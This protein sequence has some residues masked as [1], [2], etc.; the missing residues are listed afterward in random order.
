[1]G[2]VGCRC[3]VRV[4]LLLKRL[5]SVV[6]LQHTYD[7]VQVVTSKMVTYEYHGACRKHQTLLTFQTARPDR[8][9]SLSRATSIPLYMNMCAAAP[10][11]PPGK[12]ELLR[13]LRPPVRARERRPHNVRSRHRWRPAGAR[14]SRC[15]RR[16]SSN[17]RA[18]ALGAAHLLN[19]GSDAATAAVR[20]RG[21][22]TERVFTRKSLVSG[23]LRGSTHAP[24]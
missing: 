22:V 7:T 21:L 2:W 1:M 17:R 16:A 18:W 24:W 23:Q 5:L 19:L 15:L 8:M 11:R 9:E 14:S 12:Q 3:A 6:S 4:V 13:E 20:G 10:T